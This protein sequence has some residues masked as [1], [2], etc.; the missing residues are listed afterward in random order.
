MT[1][2]PGRIERMQAILRA[3]PG[4]DP[5]QVAGMSWMFSPWY[6]IFICVIVLGIPAYFLITRR[7]AFYKAPQPEIP[8]TLV[9]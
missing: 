2:L 1:L 8:E 9:V 5:N 7:A 6:S 3:N 4:Y